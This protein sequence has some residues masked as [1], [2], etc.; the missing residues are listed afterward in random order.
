LISLLCAVALVAPAGAEAAST[1]YVNGAIGSA[2]NNCE[3]STDP[4]ATITQAVGDASSG[5]TIRIAAG[6]YDEGLTVTKQLSFVGAGA[7]GANET[8]IDSTGLNTPALEL[9]DGGSVSDLA[10]VT[11]DSGIDGA[12]NADGGTITADHIAATGDSATHGTDG[13]ALNAGT[14]DLSDSMATSDDTD[15]SIDQNTTCPYVATQNGAGLEISGGTANVSASMITAVDGIALRVHTTTDPSSISDSVI[16]SSGVEDDTTNP[17]DGWP[18]IEQGAAVTLT[19]TGDTIYNGT[20]A[21]SNGAGTP[22]AVDA[23]AVEPVGTG[24]AV[25]AHNTIF[26]AAAGGTGGAD[27]DFVQNQSPQSANDG[28]VTADHSSYSTVTVTGTGTVTPLDTAGNIDND[29][30]FADPGDG[31]FALPSG[32]PLIGAGDPSVLTAGETDADGA[33][34]ASSCSGGVTVVDMGA[35]ES[36]APAC[37]AAG[38]SPKPGSTSYAYLG[39]GLGGSDTDGYEQLSIG[40][41]GLLA[42]LS[43]FEVDSVSPNGAGSLVTG[44]ASP[45]LY[46]LEQAS[47]SQNNVLQ[48][49]QI[50]SGGQL[51]PG[52]TI[53]PPAGDGIPA[54]S[55][56]ADGRD[57]YVEVRVGTGGSEQIAIDHYSVTASGSAT[58]DGSAYELPTGTQGAALAVDGNGRVYA[59]ANHGDGS[60]T[61]YSLRLNS[62]GSLTEEDSLA[63]PVDGGLVAAPDGSEAAVLVA[64]TTTDAG[65]SNGAVYSVKISAAGALSTPAVASV[66]SSGASGVSSNNPS[67]AVFSPDSKTLYVSN[68]DVFDSGDD[69]EQYG[70]LI[71][72]FAVG[73]DGGL[74]A[75]N[76]TPNPVQGDEFDTAPVI[77]PDGA[78]LYV[79]DNG[80]EPT[81][82]TIDQFTISSPGVLA[83]KSPASL[84]TDTYQGSFALVTPPASSGG[85]G[86]PPPVTVTSIPPPPAVQIDPGVA[87]I[88]GTIT[89]AASKKP[90]AGAT[91]TVCP[92]GKLLTSSCVQTSTDGSGRY[93]VSVGAG[94]WFLQVDPPTGL[95]GASA[96]VTVEAVGETVQNFALSAPV[97]V[98]DGV[99][100]NT[101][102]GAVSSGVPTV[103]WA[104]PFS[105]SVPVGAKA[106]Q[107][108]NTTVLV[109][110]I[111]GI[112]LDT[113]STQ[114]SGYDLAGILLYGVHYGAAG[115]PTGMTAPLVGEVECNA[116]CT[117]LDAGGADPLFGSPG[118]V[119]APGPGGTTL[120]VTAS[121]NG[122]PITLTVKYYYAPPL[123]SGPDPFADTSIDIGPNEP[124]A[125]TGLEGALGQEMSELEKE[126]DE[127]GDDADNV[128]GSQDDAPTDV[129]SVDESV[130]GAIDYYDDG[131]AGVDGTQTTDDGT[132]NVEDYYPDSDD[133][134][135]TDDVAA[136]LAGA[137]SAPDSPLGN[138]NAGQQAEYDFDAQAMIDLAANYAGEPDDQAPQFDSVD[139]AVSQIEDAANDYE[140][141]P[142][143][144]AQ[145]VTD[146]DYALNHGNLTEAEADQAEKQLDDDITQMFPDASTDTDDGDDDA[147]DPADNPNPFANVVSF[148]TAGYPDTEDGLSDFLAFANA[149]AQGHD[150]QG[151]DAQDFWSDV[152]DAAEQAFPN[153]EAAREATDDAL[154]NL[155]GDGW[156][157]PSG[158]V[159]TT[160]RIPL[161]GAVVTLT[162]S[163]TKRGKQVRVP[164]GSTIMSPGNRVN[165]GRTT[166]QG[167]FGWDTLRGYYEIRATHSGCKATHTSVFSV[168][169]PRSNLVLSLRC[170]KL[171][172]KAT[173]VVVKVL[174]RGHG[175]AAVRVTVSAKR[176]HARAGTLLG[177][178]TVRTSGEKPVTVGL[179]SKGV[180]LVD[181]I[182]RSASVA[183]TASYG[184]NGLYAAGSGRS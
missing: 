172:R 70:A 69:V 146:A 5:D 112:G 162:R 16:E 45:Q 60:S 165:P 163:A 51:T 15:A 28:M 103:N 23:L 135:S 52:T 105:F 4:C 27:I 3:T 169:P 115:T 82:G 11:H 84:S 43:P 58:A 46:A 147:N 148:D 39:H 47:G 36:P 104:T 63:M 74:T 118:V 120:I 176:G 6:T 55:L 32:S 67:G 26:E 94:T 86:P 62:D 114:G 174:G 44:S 122:D 150:L 1:W 80:G 113:S 128:D 34:R 119:L 164:K 57:L 121:A 14:L 160:S 152:Q 133:G 149:V 138:L 161:A 76:P 145:F 129:Q 2:G 157:D 90:I 111:T 31:N 166:V 22:P 153:A 143:G 168:P 141:T 126:P 123:V 142:D 100:F 130:H 61:L 30:A 170:H 88:T 98:S 140:D 107:P 21:A 156:I 54:A 38:P 106:H 173:K 155:F 116:A 42:K 110:H 97:G 49:Y 79:P 92:K 85:G 96:F 78:S 10:M 89:N 50:G 159:R 171:K 144:L 91:L 109:A 83:A 180:A 136:I 167:L 9:Q 125:S 151:E 17:C 131:D 102:S 132:D 183:V 8:L 59:L 178:L 73:P 12:F 179:D 158:L 41:G 18:A 154:D 75:D 71:A 139:D 53:T 29:P 182:T 99:V 66:R 68:N 93:K 134:L 72:A 87:G 20:V 56:T 48:Q 81:S 7:S 117:D 177:A 108:P 33:T 37:P 65:Q 175:A 40:S 24:V 184:G 77:S 19:L 127:N 124:A 35:V 13:I 25:V 95:F 64:G 101:P 181:V 137:Q